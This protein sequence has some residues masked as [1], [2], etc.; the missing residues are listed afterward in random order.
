[1]ERIIIHSLLLVVT[2][3]LHDY[4]SLYSTINYY[5]SS[6]TRVSEKEYSEAANIHP[7]LRTRLNNFRRQKEAMK[8]EAERS[9]EDIVAIRPEWTTVDRILASRYAG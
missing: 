7:R 1:M 5:L 8:K 9:G 3:S 6:K 2:C 4:I